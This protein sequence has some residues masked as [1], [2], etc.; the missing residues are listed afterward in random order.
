MSA[1]AEIKEFIS[2][3]VE[4]VKNLIEFLTYDMWRLDFSKPQRFSEKVIHRIQDGELTP[5]RQNLELF[6]DLA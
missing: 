4:T 1:V 6:R 3:V 2:K 5:G